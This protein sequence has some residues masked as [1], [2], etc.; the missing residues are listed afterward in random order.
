MRA[1]G[2][3]GPRHACDGGNARIAVGRGG[4]RE[5]PVLAQ[6]AGKGVPSRSVL[7]N[8]PFLRR[9]RVSRPSLPPGLFAGSALAL[10]SSP[11]EPCAE[12]LPALWSWVARH[13]TPPS[14]IL[15][16]RPDPATLG[17]ALVKQAHALGG[18]DDPGARWWLSVS[19]LDA[20]RPYALQV[21]RPVDALRSLAAAFDEPSFIL[22]DE[23]SGV[24][25]AVD[26]EEWDV[27][28][29]TRGAPPAD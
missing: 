15:P 19:G 5:L 20:A 16:G 12:D 11:T 23:A 8:R 7:A 1:R 2:A 6:R 3:G 10:E 18:L 24:V 26:T 22:V 25:L 4:L 21:D 14:L 17:D 29:F 28:L 13:A 27:R 9:R